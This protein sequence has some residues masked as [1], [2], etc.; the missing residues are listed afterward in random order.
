MYCRTYLYNIYEQ[1]D[2]IYTH[3]L[4]LKHIYS[5]T[6][7]QL[8]N[9]TSLIKDTYNTTLYF[10]FIDLWGRFLKLTCFIDQ[11]IILFFCYAEIDCTLNYIVLQWFHITLTN[12]A[13]V[14][15]SLI[16]PVLPHTYISP[17]TGIVKLIA[18][19]HNR[20]IP[21][22]NMVFDTRWAVINEI[23]SGTTNCISEQNNHLH[24]FVVKI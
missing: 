7:D 24:N 22:F 21:G 2:M 19:G 1:P 12:R 3:E 6:Y 5:N 14:V 17:I 18:P 10:E 9:F 16:S 23:L 11:I 4:Y 15:S 8:V 13:I 20:H